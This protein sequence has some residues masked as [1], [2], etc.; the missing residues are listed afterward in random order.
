MISS[1]GRSYRSIL[2]SSHV[3]ITLS[4]FPRDLGSHMG[5][6]SL[7]FSHELYEKNQKITRGH[8]L[9]FN[10]KSLQFQEQR[11]Q[12]ATIMMQWFSH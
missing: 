11:I 8:D 7:F 9:N 5:T 6:N 2:W 10:D 12:E 1:L 4:F 3:T